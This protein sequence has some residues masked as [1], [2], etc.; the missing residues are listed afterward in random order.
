MGLNTFA[1]VAARHVPWN[2]QFVAW[3]VL[4]GRLRRED[5]PESSYAN[6]VDVVAVGRYSLHRSYGQY[7]PVSMTTSPGHVVIPHEVF[8]PKPLVVLQ[9]RRRQVI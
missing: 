7:P 6:W 5:V 9:Q 3:W 8:I 1:L 4:F 2:R